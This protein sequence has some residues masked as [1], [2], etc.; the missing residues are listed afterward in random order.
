MIDLINYKKLYFVG[1]GGISMSGIA[2][3][4]KKW[5]FIVLGSDSSVSSQTEWLEKQGIKVNIGQSADNI[6]NDIDL[7]IYTAAIKED[8]PELVRAREL[9][10]KCIERYI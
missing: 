9:N 8:N 10:I 7:V 5:D 2:V 4:L 6:E 1:I 3:I